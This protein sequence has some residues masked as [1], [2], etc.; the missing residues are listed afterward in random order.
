MLEEVYQK[1]GLTTILSI[2]YSYTPDWGLNYDRNLLY[3]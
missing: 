3:S 2:E 1:Y